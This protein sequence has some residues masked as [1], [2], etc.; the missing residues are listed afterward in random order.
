MR[1]KEHI[2]MHALLAEVTRYLIEEETMS[3][4]MLSTYDALAT[5][6]S[7]IHKPKENHREAVMALSSAIEPCLEERMTTGQQQSVN[8]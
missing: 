7:S 2:H 3:A 5:R 6:P 4:E 8:L 1:K